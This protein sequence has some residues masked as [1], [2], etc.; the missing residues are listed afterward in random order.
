MDAHQSNHAVLLHLRRETENDFFDH[1][2]ER[3]RSLIIGVH[4]SET[5]M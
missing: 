3:N 2:I 1:T 5:E 4:S